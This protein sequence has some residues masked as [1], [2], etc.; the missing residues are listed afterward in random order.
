[1]VDLIAGVA[2]LGVLAATI[3]WTWCAWVLLELVIER[4]R[5]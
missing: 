1:M 4:C 2:V 3:V 5:A